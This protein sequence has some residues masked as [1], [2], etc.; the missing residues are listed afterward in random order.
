M[1]Q[2]IIT[3]LIDDLTGKEAD[4]SLTF[5]LDGK[6][7]EIDLTTANADKLREILKPYTEAGRK[8]GG[9]GGASGRGRGAAAKSSSEDTAAIRAWAKE[10]G[11]EVNDRG[12][13]PATIREAYAKA[14]G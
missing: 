11:Y 6:T 5:G 14:N 8:T 9:K 12:R 3:K 1:A 2:Q 13:V 10:N 7:Y 4:E